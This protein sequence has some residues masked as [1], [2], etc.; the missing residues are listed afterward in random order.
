MSIGCDSI[1]IHVVLR[2]IRPH[3]AYRPLRV[4]QL[5]GPG[6]YI[7]SDEPII[8]GERC[9]TNLGKSLR[10]IAHPGPIANP[11]TARMEQQNSW[12][13]DVSRSWEIGIEYEAFT[14]DLP[15]YD[16]KFRRPA[17]G[18]S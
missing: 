3:P 6:V 18:R 16:V 14:V 13:Q 11:E 4:I 17:R 9:V 15:I 1:R 12:T 5:S 10:R 7:S 2:R 8:Y